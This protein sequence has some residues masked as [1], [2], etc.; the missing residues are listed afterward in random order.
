ERQPM[1]P[2]TAVPVGWTYA[3]CH[4]FGLSLFEWSP[5]QPLVAQVVYPT[6]WA[7]NRGRGLL[8]LGLLEP[9][10]AAVDWYAWMPLPDDFRH[11]YGRPQLT[12]VATDRGLLAGLTADRHARMDQSPRQ[13]HWMAV[14]PMPPGQPSPPGPPAPAFTMRFGSSF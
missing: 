6:P 2:G 8:R 12:L 11:A 14:L 4:S 1:D 7:V 9:S 5:E 13:N 10:T 3:T